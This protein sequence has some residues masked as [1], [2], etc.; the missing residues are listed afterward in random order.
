MSKTLDFP[1]RRRSSET[2]VALHCSG[3]SAKQWRPLRAALGSRF[4]FLT[5]ENYGCESRGDWHGRHAFSLS[6]D[7]SI[8]IDMID[9][10][11]SPVHLIGHS[12]GGALA[13]HIALARPDKVASM[14]LYEPCAYY[15]LRQ[16]GMAGEQGFSEIMELNG[17][18]RDQV[19]VG[20]FL[21]AMSSFVDYW[22]GY[23]AWDELKP[24]LQALMLRWAPKAPLEFHALMEEPVLLST[25]AE[26]QVPVLLMRGEHTPAPTGAI[27]QALMERMP[28]CRMIDVSGAGHMGH[29]THADDVHAA[30]FEHLADYA[31]QSAPD[32]GGDAPLVEDSDD[33]V[34]AS[35]DPLDTASATT[36]QLAK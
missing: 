15:L 8:A 25:Y 16:I 13:L 29:V 30:I 14:V 6:D 33:D 1:T 23:D 18:V 36:P 32:H 21:A 20:D 10:C 27:A 31:S 2:I 35:H 34:P 4:E 26:L 7:A 9:R 17:F 5:P 12:Y 28:N 11:Q 19:A 3:W 22:N 24:E